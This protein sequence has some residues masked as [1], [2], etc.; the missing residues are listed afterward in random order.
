MKQNGAFM[1]DDAPSNYPYESLST[2]QKQAYDIIMAHYNQGQNIEPLNM[3][4]QGTTG[5]KKSYLIGALH[6]AFQD[7][8]STE[9]SCLLLLAPT[10]VGAFNIDATTIHG[11]L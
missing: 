1:D 8:P 2:K 4:I 11:A 6:Q 10:E 7:L 3:I 9:C 5:I